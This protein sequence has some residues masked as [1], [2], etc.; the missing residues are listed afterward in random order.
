M[1]KGLYLVKP[2]EAG[3]MSLWPFWCMLGGSFKP[4]GD[5]LGYETATAALICS[6]SILVAQFNYQA[7]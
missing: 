3:E 1:K 5:D 2:P 6:F 4:A 7:D